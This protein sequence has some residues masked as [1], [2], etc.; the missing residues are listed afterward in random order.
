MHKGRPWRAA[1]FV[2]AVH[3]A[4]SLSSHSSFVCLSDI[5][6]VNT[7]SFMAS[8]GRLLGTYIE[9]TESSLNERVPM[10]D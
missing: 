9:K 5:L 10:E 4:V 1:K 7:S 2:S 3:V 8:S 6:R